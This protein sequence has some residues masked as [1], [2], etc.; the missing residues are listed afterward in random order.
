MREPTEHGRDAD[1]ESN[2][3][4]PSTDFPG[5]DGRTILLWMGACA[6]IG[7]SVAFSLQLPDWMQLW[8]DP[9]L[10]LVGVVFLVVFLFAFVPFFFR[11]FLS[12]F[13]KTGTT[14]SPAEPSSCNTQA[15]H[16]E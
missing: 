11:T 8:F 10:F 5:Q 16:H 4:S 13:S 14:N 15:K 12:L 1:E 3:P 6:A 7:L 9:R 2:S